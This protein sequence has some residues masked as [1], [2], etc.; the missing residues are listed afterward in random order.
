MQIKCPEALVLLYS[1]VSVVHGGPL[2]PEPT[3][4]AI[5]IVGEEGTPPCDVLDHPL[6]L[7]EAAVGGG[8]HCQG[9]NQEEE[10]MP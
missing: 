8:Y 5:A 2:A 1:P 10:T 4:A 6:K 3:V 7:P 9:E